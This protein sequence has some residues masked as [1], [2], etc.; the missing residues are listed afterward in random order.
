MNMLNCKICSSEVL[1]TEEKCSTCHWYAGPPNVRAAEKQEERDALE[2]RYINA[3]EKARTDGNEQYLASFDDSMKKTC[4]VIN[5]DLDFLHQF[6]ANSKLIYTNYRLGVEGQSRRP[7]NDR[8]DK[9]RETIG[10]MLFGHFAKEIRYAALS[11]DGSGPKSYGGPYAMK[12][13]E[14]TI[15]NRATLLE[16]NS[17]VFIAKH[18]IQP[19]QNIPLGHTSIWSERHKLAVAKLAD[20]ISP[21]MTEQDHSQILLFSEGDRNTDEFIEVLI[22]GGFDNKAIESVKGVSSVKGKYERAVISKIKDNLKKAR[23]D[24]V[25]E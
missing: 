4:A 3:I 24:W 5:V 8:D 18:N 11:R 21:N 2:A 10:A 15:S 23:K 14:V 13:R 17:Y 19:R 25:E 16:D 7:A 1:D 6:I 22:F 12:L 20:S 9:D